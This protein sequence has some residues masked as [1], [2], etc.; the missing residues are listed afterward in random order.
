MILVDANLLIYATHT[1]AAQHEAAK[2]WLEHSLSSG[3]RVGLPWAS[4]LAFVRLT[5]NPR[6]FE[7][8]L[9]V[10]QA[11][12]LIAEWLALPAVW[13]PGATERHVQL[14][15]KLLGEAGSGGNLV[16]DAHLAALSVEHGLMLC[17]TDRDFAKFTGLNWHNPL[18]SLRAEDRCLP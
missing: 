6:V 2:A 8:P 11:T 18:T 7:R 4:L 15:T 17:S 3:M 9:S 14:F 13:T 16:A 10:Q 5:T 12:E 1:E